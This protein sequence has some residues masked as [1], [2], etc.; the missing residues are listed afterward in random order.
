MIPK[1]IHYTWF[2]NEPL[3]AEIQACID[4]WHKHMPDYTIMKWDMESI[5]GIDNI[6]MREAIA[7]RK[8]A[9]AADFVRLYAVYHHGGIYLDTDM[10]ILRP[11]DPLLG[12]R[13]F[14]G[15]ENAFHLMEHRTE[16][17]LS[18]H[19]FGA[20][21][22]HPFVKRCLDYYEGR[23]FVTGTCPDLP[24]SL[25][26]NMT[27]MPYIQSE[28]AKQ[29]GYNPSSLRN[30]RQDLPDGLTVYPSGYFDPGQP[31]PESFGQHLALGSWRESRITHPKV[32]WRH[33]IERQIVAIFRS[34]LAG[35]G[36]EVIKKN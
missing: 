7:K 36:Y 18:S 32:D 1:I 14:I 25:T 34:I 11:L 20:E 26:L 9:F 30:V 19:C 17:F 16:H 3:S 31:G 12:H 28:I 22:R 6:F 2:S 15:R 21:P 10:K 24:V 33:K 35:M 13:A 4:S 29:W 23:R 5:A 27:L 8:W